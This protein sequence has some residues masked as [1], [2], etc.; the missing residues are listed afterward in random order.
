LLEPF[1][2]ATPAGRALTVLATGAGAMT[3]SH[4]NDS[5]FWVVA[6]FTGLDTAT[7]LRTQ[8]VSTLFQGVTGISIILVL[9][10]VL[11]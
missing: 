9:G 7:A 4:L 5:F 2:L 8:T 10:W 11:L 6:Q 1:G 3:V